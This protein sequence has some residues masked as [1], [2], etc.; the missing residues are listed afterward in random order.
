MYDLSVRLPWSQSRD[1]QSID[2]FDPWRDALWNSGLAKHGGGSGRVGW[3][4]GVVH[5]G[6]MMTKNFGRPRL[7]MRALKSPRRN[8]RC[9]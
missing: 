4:E 2:S 3:G 5:R 6:R 9:L 8:M 7:V 1:E